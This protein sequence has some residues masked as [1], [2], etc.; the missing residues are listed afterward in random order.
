MNKVKSFY[1]KEMVEELRG[2]SPLDLDDANYFADK[3]Q[4]TVK[5]IIQKCLHEQITYL[6]TVHEKHPLTFRPTKL[7]YIKRI[8]AIARTGLPGLDR[9]PVATL[10]VLSERLA[11]Y[12]NNG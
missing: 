2:A 1:T 12:S 9:T 5:S 7:D 8:E 4:T 3:W 6:P 11:R 10:K